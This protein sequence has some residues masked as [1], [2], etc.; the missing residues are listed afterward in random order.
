M[1]YDLILS[2]GCAKLA[3]LAS[4][5]ASLALYWING[6][7][8]FALAIPAALCCMLGGYLGARLAVRGGAKWVRPFIFLVLGLLFVK[9]GYELVQGL[10]A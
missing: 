7:V 4:N 9:T 2:S 8:F 3:N 5:L 1:G 10:M 6:K